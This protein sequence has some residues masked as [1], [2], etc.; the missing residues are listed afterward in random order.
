LHSK[1]DADAVHS[2]AEAKA[3]HSKAE[4]MGFKDISQLYKDDNNVHTVQLYIRDQ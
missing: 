4:A 1:A 3:M 2:K